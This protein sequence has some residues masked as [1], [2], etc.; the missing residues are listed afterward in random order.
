MEFGLQVDSRSFF[1]FFSLLEEDVQKLP[2]KEGFMAMLHSLPHQIITTLTF[3]KLRGG[4]SI[5]GF[6]LSVV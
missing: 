2:K 6:S 5:P 3:R 1:F 4:G